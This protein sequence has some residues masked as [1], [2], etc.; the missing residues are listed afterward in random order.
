MGVRQLTAAIVNCTIGAGIFV[1]PALVFQDMGAAAPLAFLICAVVMGCICTTLAVAGSR[2]D[3][4][5]GIYAYVEIAF[6]PFV[7]FLAGVLQWL[8]GLLAAAGVLTAL[9]DQ[10]ATLIPGFGVVSRI[11]ILIVIVA[12]LAVLNVRGVRLGTRLIEIVTAVKL[13]PLL[14]FVVAGAFF[15]DSSVIAW[16]AVPGM[17][18][19]GRSV[20]LLIFAYSGVEVALAPSGEVRDPAATIPRAVFAALTATTALYIAIQLVAQG[21]SGPLLAG[22]AGAPLAAA[23]GRFLGS[24]G[25]VLM[26]LGAASS[27][28]GYLC[29]DMLSTPRSFYALARDGLLPAAFARI[30]PEYRTPASAICAHAVCLVLLAGTNSF[31]SLAIISNVGLLLLYLVACGAAL[32]L[33][34]R[35]VRT[36]SAPFTFPGVSLGP[37]VGAL[38]ILLILSTATPHEF[39]ITLAVLVVAA[40]LYAVRQHL[41][42]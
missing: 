9:L 25:V 15:I 21:V 4:T 16:P 14:L 5:G 29:G 30:H 28:F 6:G 34:R 11:A 7:G 37:V 2:V 18:A 12:T 17:R 8:T 38:L 40:I 32:E 27:M 20:L 24:T 13:T 22:D 31:Q 36:A 33:A 19:I 42:A 3:L 1:L 26:L 41:S 23:A 39:A 35:N 10:L